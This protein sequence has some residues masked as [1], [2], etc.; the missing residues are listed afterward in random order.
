MKKE[1]AITILE[2]LK[3]Y[4]NNPKYW[5]CML[6]REDNEA[7]DLAIIALKESKEGE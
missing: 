2:E 1:E 6:T 5:D 7:I 3:D 4:Y